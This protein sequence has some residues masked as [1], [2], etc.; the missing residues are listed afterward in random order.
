MVMFYYNTAVCLGVE[1]I[2]G[3]ITLKF[4]FPELYI[5][6]NPA[7]EHYLIAFVTWSIHTIVMSV[8]PTDGGVKGKGCHLAAAG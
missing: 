5:Y 4:F 8:S 6:L 3:Y 1:W 2:S 7:F